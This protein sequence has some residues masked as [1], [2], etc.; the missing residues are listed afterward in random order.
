M[1]FFFSAYQSEVKVNMFMNIKEKT[2]K[3]PEKIHDN[4]PIYYLKPI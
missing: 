4:S 3:C 1:K 2:L